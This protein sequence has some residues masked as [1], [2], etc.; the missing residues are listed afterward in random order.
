MMGGGFLNSRFA[1]RLRQKE[2]LS[3][4]VASTFMAS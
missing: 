1:V 3:Y 2:G 4:G